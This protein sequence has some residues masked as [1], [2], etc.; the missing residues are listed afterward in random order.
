MK[1][2]FC[3]VLAKQ[4]NSPAYQLQEKIGEGG[5]GY[6]YR[7]TQIST[8]Q[9]VAIKFLSISPEFDDAKKARYIERFERETILG[10]RLQHPNIVRLLDKGSC[11]DLLYAVFEYVDGK[12]LKQTLAESGSLAPI[13]AAEVMTQVLDALAHA[14]QQ[15]VIHRDIKPANIMLIKQGTRTHAKVLD[16][17]IGTLVSEARLQ[18]YK[19]ITLTQETL[20]TPSYSAP[21]Q[22][23]G[24]PPTLTTDLYVWGLVFIEC[25]TGQPA[26]SGG[27]LASVFHKQLSQSNVPLPAA[28][29]G[30]PISALLRRVLHKK[31]HERS[32]NAQAL[33]DELVQINF[34]NLVGDMRSTTKVKIRHDITLSNAGIDETIISNKAAYYT[35]L[36]ERKQITALCINLSVHAVAD[37]IIDHEVVDTLHRDQKNQCLDMVIRYGAH[38][39]GTLGDTMLFYFGYPVASDND[40][41]L[42]ARSALDIISSLY[43]RN[44]LLK[45]SQGIELDVRIGIHTGLMTCYADAT[46]QGNTANIAMQLARLACKDKILCSDI[47]QKKLQTYI[48]FEPAQS[49]VLGV[50]KTTSALFNLTAERH[51]EAFGFLRS[52]QSNY[53]FIGREQELKQLTALLNNRESEGESIS[54][55]AHVY[56]EA[57]IGKSRLLFELRNSAPL[58]LH[59]VAQ[60]LP[61]HQNNA[62]YPILNVIKYKYSLDALSPAA[63]LQKLRDEIVTL[64]QVEEQDA[65]PVLCSWLGLPLPQDMPTLALSPDKQKQVLF[66]TL[67]TLLVCQDTLM[68]Q[69]ANLFI[70]E[71]MHWADPTSI[72]FIAC[73]SSDKRFTAS[74]HLFI[75]TSRKPLPESLH[76]SGFELLELVK[77]TNKNTRE[78]VR[79]LFDKENVSANLL[80]IVVS[81]SDGI[82]LFIEELVNMLK[83]KGLVHKLNG[84]FDFT[85]PDKQDEVPSSLRDSLQQKLDT[86]VHAKETVQLAATIGREFDYDLLVAASRH[87]EAQVQNDLN[88]L[89]DA[90][91]IYQLRKVSGDSYLFKH[92]LVRDAAYEGI[93]TQALKHSHLQIADSLEKFFP[94]ITEKE[95]A[96]VAQHFASAENFLDAVNYGIRAAKQSLQGAAFSETVSQAKQVELWNTNLGE[97][98]QIDT[99]LELNKILTTVSMHTDGWASDQI[100]EYTRQSIELLNSKRGYE[101]KELIKYLWWKIMQSLVAGERAL[102]AEVVQEIEELLD[103]ASASD[104]SAIL[105][106]IGY[107][108]YTE[109]N[110]QKGREFLELAVNY[111]LEVDQDSE[112]FKIY[113]WH[114]SVFALASLA[115]VCWDMGDT[116]LALKYVE[117]A[118]NRARDADDIGTLGITLMYAS[119]V[120]QY[121]NDKASCLNTSEELLTLSKEHDLP[122]FDA[123]GRLTFS[124]ATDDDSKQQQSLELLK[125][126][127][128]RHA[129]AYFSSLIA[130][131]YISSGAIKKAIERFD[132]CIDLCQTIGEHYYE[133]QLYHRR[134]LCRVNYLP[135]QRELAKK[136]F[137]QA[138]MQAEKVGASYV[139]EK[140]KHDLSTIFNDN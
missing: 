25:L 80:D 87:N 1:P 49:C 97:E 65:I 95:P 119:I 29:V 91:L 140:V 64:A 98:E 72:E 108:Y 41:R 2:L 18:D 122:V 42:C 115:R 76:E 10:S 40:S 62:L 37:E 17:G 55:L 75:S 44:A 111:Q 89:I 74:K 90:G 85:S 116:D 45:N 84:L 131:I 86:L 9:S 34:S 113:G 60:C 20:G 82:P 77:L 121:N 118:V 127:G 81:R 51:V 101:K 96:I 48:E 106:I 129:V 53:A 15:G 22:L 73:L 93:S 52:T 21:E 102:L 105:S 46:P 4:F 109:G 71:D 137:Q 36:I 66:S 139:V 50:N 47:S 3:D 79:L 26:M 107:Y 138:L 67:I 59:H 83:Q 14:H 39:V 7:A 120:H 23:R 68:A 114:S 24:E 8:G 132:E 16:F 12:T 35:E 61:E 103:I 38:H 54:K 56:G 78:F 19:S 112:H 133:A 100:K 99:K 125:N 32:V 135:D 31:S 124:W 128:S 43:K 104:K 126:Y 27:S 70:F 117:K 110:C 58:M 57:G 134:A 94:E 92:A 63:A 6:V 33:Y 5:F 11:E 136:D 30:H 69:Q 88:E 123:Y 28:I 13:A 130:D